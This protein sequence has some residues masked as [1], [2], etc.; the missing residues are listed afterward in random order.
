[1]TVLTSQV[2]ESR[3]YSDGASE[4]RTPA[5]KVKGEKMT[6][7]STLSII[8]KSSVCSRER[9]AL[10]IRQI[11]PVPR[12]TRPLKNV[13]PRASTSTNR[14]FIEKD[15]AEIRLLTLKIVISKLADMAIK[16][17]VT[18]VPYRDS[19]LYVTADTDTNLK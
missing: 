18:H 16:K 8:G 9:E 5:G 17:N 14:E 7:I 13:M 1:M 3:A 15:T 10:L 6:R 2:I 12:G 4:M 19:K 11:L